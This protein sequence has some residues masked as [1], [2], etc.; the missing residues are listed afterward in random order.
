MLKIVT[1]MRPLHFLPILEIALAFNYSPFLQ[2][3]A[4][5]CQYPVSLEGRILVSTDRSRVAMEHAFPIPLVRG[6]TLRDIARVPAISSVVSEAVP[7]GLDQVF[8]KV[9][10]SLAARGITIL[11]TAL[12]PRTFNAAW[13][14][15]QHRLE[16]VHANGLE[17]P[18]LVVPTCQGF[19]LVHPIFN[20]VWALPPLPQILQE[21]VYQVLISLIWHRLLSGAVQHPNGK[22]LQSKDI[23]RAAVR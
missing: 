11:A 14:H 7:L 16:V 1:K 4:T 9:H 22:L 17:V 13:L 10:P 8:A 2:S 21:L 5:V 12:A 3:R 6:P 15:A 18:V 19:V 20:A 23:S